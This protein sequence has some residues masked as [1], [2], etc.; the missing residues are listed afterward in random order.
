MI[1]T[2]ARPPAGESRT[3]RRRVVAWRVVEAETNW[4]PVPFA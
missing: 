2:D 3:L 4:Y 1:G